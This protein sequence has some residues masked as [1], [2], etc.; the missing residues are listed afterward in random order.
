MTLTASAQAASLDPAVPPGRDLGGFPVAIVGHGLDYTDA[1]IAQRLARDGE[2]EITGYDFIDNDR[3]PFARDS[4]DSAASDTKSARIILAEGQATSLIAVRADVND[5]GSLAKA[6]GFAARSPT[7]VIVVLAPY[8]DRQMHNV[9]HAASRHFS[10]KLFIVPAGDDRIYFDEAYPTLPQDMPNLIV[11]TTS[12]EDGSRAAQANFGSQVVDV[13]VPIGTIEVGLAIS[14]TDE[15]CPTTWAASRVAA[16]AAR[17]IAVE[18]DKSA[19]G[20]KARIVSLAQPSA[21]DQK[22]KTSKSGWIKQPRR[23][24]WLE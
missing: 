13:A 16:L 12:N 21:E 7:R 2:G 4:D 20:L 8:A 6:I 9:L 1:A 3:R 5:T 10:E 18:P 23:H 22:N 15:R 17:L 14:E 19:S 11:V 24:F